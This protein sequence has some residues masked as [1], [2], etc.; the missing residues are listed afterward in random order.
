MRKGFTC[1]EKRARA[2]CV[3]DMVFVP[4]ELSVVIVGVVWGRKTSRAQFGY[5]LAP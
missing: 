3:G 4:C 2:V 5:E 1:A